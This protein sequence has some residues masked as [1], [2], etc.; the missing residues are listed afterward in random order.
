M[1]YPGTI[2]LEEKTFEALLTD[3]CRSYKTHGF[4]DI[5]LLGDS[6]GNQTGMKNVAEELNKKCHKEAARA[7]YL[8]EYYTEDRWSY[9][10]LKTLGITQIDKSKPAGQ[11]DQR[12]DTR[13]NMHDDIY[14]EAQVAV[15]DPTLIRAEQR[16]KAGLLSLHGVD[17]TPVNT[18]VLTGKKLAAY[19]AQITARA[20][21]NSILKLR[22]RN[23]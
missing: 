14:Y 9:D 19:R 15:Q 8:A 22:G 17:E 6:G 23:L 20:F 21:K 13:N 2:S 3:I 4:R 18:L 16:Q 12:S 5:I 1:N 10:F 11:Q 7:H